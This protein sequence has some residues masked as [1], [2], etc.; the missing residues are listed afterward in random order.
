M[1]FSYTRQNLPPFSPLTERR[2]C[3]K[4]NFWR[5]TST[6]Q[7]SGRGLLKYLKQ[8]KVTVQIP[9]LKHIADRL[10]SLSKWY[11]I[12][13]NSRFEKLLESK[14]FQFLHLPTGV[15]FIFVHFWVRGGLIAHC[16]IGGV[17][18]LC[19]YS[20]HTHGKIKWHNYCSCCC[21]VLLHCTSFPTSSDHHLFE[22]L[23]LVVPRD[24][25]DSVF[26]YK[27]QA[28]VAVSWKKCVVLLCF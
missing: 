11:E 2:W 19:F 28:F 5:N 7:P 1:N 21:A 26:T 20:L 4:R 25:L 14:T 22:K 12:T 6:L 17:P 13:R 15:L 9:Q 23:S 3:W 8:L 24:N 10:K 27:T 18:P 16:G